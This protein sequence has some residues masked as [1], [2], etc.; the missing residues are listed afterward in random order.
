M[1]SSIADDR[2]GKIYHTKRKKVKGIRINN[3]TFIYQIYKL[4]TD[5]SEYE[6]ISTHLSLRYYNL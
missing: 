1:N 5:S 2:R 6:K 3:T 4:D